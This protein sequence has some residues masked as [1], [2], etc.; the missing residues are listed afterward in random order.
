MWKEMVM[1]GGM[2]ILVALI[3][4]WYTRYHSRNDKWRESVDEQLKK[5]S[6][7]IAVQN[8]ER[9]HV[10]NQLEHILTQLGMIAHRIDS[11]FTLRRE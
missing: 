8:A 3:S 10:S 11:L 4:A 5:H 6:E 1:T 2:G 9:I 7:A